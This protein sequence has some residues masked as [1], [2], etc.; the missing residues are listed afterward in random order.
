MLTA[1]PNLAVFKAGAG[2]PPSGGTALTISD[3]E[4]WDQSDTFD[5]TVT[6]QSGATLEIS[7][8]I[9][10]SSSSKI[11][12]Q[13][14]G[15]LDIVAGGSLDA[16]TPPSSLLWLG[17]SETESRSAIRI[18]LEDYTGGV[19]VEIHSMYSQSLF[20][21]TYHL[22]NG[23]SGNMTG[24]SLNIS[25]DASDTD[26]WVSFSGYAFGTLAI[27]EIAIDPT[28]GSTTTYLAADLDHRNWMLAGDV[29]FTVEVEG[30]LVL[31]GGSIFGAGITVDGQMKMLG[32]E[33][34]RSGPIMVAEQG[35]INL[36]AGV[37]N[38][39]RVDHDIEGGIA[40]NMIIASEVSTT[41]GYIDVYERVIIDQKIK[42]AASSVS[43]WVTG[44]GPE[45]KTSNPTISDLQGLSPI[46]SGGSR[47]VEILYSNRTIWTENATIEVLNFRTAWN[48]KSGE[49]E[50]YNG[51]EKLSFEPLHIYSGATPYLTII[52]INPGLTT[53]EIGRSIKVNATIRNDGEAAAHVALNCTTGENNT[54]ADVGLPD[55]VLPALSSASVSFRWASFEPGTH[56]IT[57]AIYTPTQ[58]IDE[59]AWGGAPVTSSDVVW[60]PISETASGALGFLAMVLVGLLI[61]IVVFIQFQTKSKENTTYMVDSEFDDEAE[62]KH[63]ELEI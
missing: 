18:P 13:T 15:S 25:F 17:Y 48:P 56:N 57:C 61:A 20:G 2:E 30:S 4:I 32:G 51:T 11:I 44:L 16:I 38:G 45:E 63:R 21:F 23:S 10:V 41:G 22:S 5:G 47:T 43:Y 49:I 42:F 14:G 29:G 46:D 26:G 9:Q 19:D 53:G 52:S 27:D 34:V 55:L 33:L 50:N 62:E 37:L 3:A 1:A 28:I 59:N 31:N 24:S 6:I 12:V 58:L 39:S 54:P 35:S 8:S 40:S 36:T 7:A 60:A